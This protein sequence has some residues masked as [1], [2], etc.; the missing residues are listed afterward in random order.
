MSLR[1][2]VARRIP[3]IGYRLSWRRSELRF[4]KMCWRF[5]HSSARDKQ[6]CHDRGWML[7][8]LRSFSPRIMDGRSCGD[9]FL[10]WHHNFI[11]KIMISAYFT[12]QGFVFVEALL[13]PEQFSKQRSIYECLSSKNAG[14]RLLDVYWQRETSQ[15]C[16]APS[17]N[18]RAGFTRLAQSPYSPDLTPYN[19]FLFG[20][21]KKQLDVKNCTSQNEVI[22]LVRLFWPRSPF[23]SSDKSSTNGLRDYTSVLRMMGGIS[24]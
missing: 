3:H 12:R 11:E 18:W 7:D 14:S 2:C 13:E 9:I 16:F 4:V 17:E 21:L 1:F 22:S 20:Y 23:E 10:N 6:S 5:W 24:K 15:F 8:F 19:F